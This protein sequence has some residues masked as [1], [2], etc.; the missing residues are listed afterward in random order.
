[1]VWAHPG[2]VKPWVYISAWTTS[3]LSH[4]QNTA[5]ELKERKEKKAEKRH[6]LGFWHTD[7]KGQ[8]EKQKRSSIYTSQA[9]FWCTVQS[10][11]ITHA[12]SILFTLMSKAITG[13][14]QSCDFR[15]FRFMCNAK[16]LYQKRTFRGKKNCLHL[17]GVKSAMLDLFT[18]RKDLHLI[19]GD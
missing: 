16:L 13:H 7:Q 15:H 17:K 12:S 14:S 6:I 19:F 11:T 2:A 8:Q 4:Q 18:Y 3:A 5:L 10:C 1:M 9:L